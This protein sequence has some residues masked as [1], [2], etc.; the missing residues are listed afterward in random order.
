MIFILIERIFG[1]YSQCVNSDP[2]ITYGQEELI[3]YDSSEGK[4]KLLYLL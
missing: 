4:Y 2:T 3:R 1:A